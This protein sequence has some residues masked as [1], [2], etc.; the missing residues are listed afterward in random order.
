MSSPGLRLNRSKLVVLSTALLHARP[1][2][3]GSWVIVTRAVKGFAPPEEDAGVSEILLGVNLLEPIDDSSCRLT[4]VNH[5][6]SSSIPLMLA[7]RVGVKSA[8]NFVKDLRRL[9][10]EGKL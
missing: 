6:Y 10:E 1:L 3:Q 2:E 9:K 5:V 4:A 8:V 7:E